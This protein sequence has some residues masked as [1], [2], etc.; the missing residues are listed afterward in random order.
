VEKELIQGALA[1][2]NWNISRAAEDLGMSRQALH[3]CI[4]KYD[5]EKSQ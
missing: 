3:D 4:R 1:S 2:R 5:L